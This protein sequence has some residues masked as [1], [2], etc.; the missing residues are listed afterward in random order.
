MMRVYLGLVA[1]LILVLEPQGACPK[2][3]T[4]LEN[5]SLPSIAMQTLKHHFDK[6]E[7][8]TSLS[9]FASRFHLTEQYKRSAGL[10][11]TLS[12]NGK[13]RACWG[14]IFPEHQN[15]V[16]ATVFTTEAALT[17]EY[18]FPPLKKE[19]LKDLKAQ[20][21]VV[22]A[23]EP[24]ESFRQLNPLRHGL[25]VRSG[26]RA[27]VI[28]PGEAKDAYYQ[29]VLSKLKAGIPSRSPCQMYRIHTD[30]FR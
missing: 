20:I 24:I 8:N 2:T 5:A 13:T 30:V 15:L 6:D 4:P 11:V 25:F 26:A 28:L 16:T 21:T 19:E 1:M 23:V 7:R 27:A 3:A 29:L 12:K 22:N 17:K 9:E 14:S 18:R 10:F